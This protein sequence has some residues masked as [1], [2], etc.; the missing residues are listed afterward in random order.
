M[1]RIHNYLSRYLERRSSLARNS[2]YRPI[3]TI[4]VS[5]GLSLLIGDAS[6]IPIRLPDI[7]EKSI[8]GPGWIRS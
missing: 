1:E 4:K 3:L 7:E 8:F 5:F 2:K 6:E